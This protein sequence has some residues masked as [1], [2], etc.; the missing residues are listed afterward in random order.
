MEKTRVAIIFGGRSAEHSI[1]LRSAKNVIRSI[2]QSKYDLVF[3]GIDMLGNW[4]HYDTAKKWSEM[5]QTG[6]L[7]LDNPVGKL[8]LQLEAKGSF[9]SSNGNEKVSVDVAFPVLHGPFGEDGSVQGMLKLASIPFVGPSLLGSAVGM[10]KDVMKRLLREAGLPIGKYICLRKGEDIPEFSFFQK[11]LGIPCFVK[12]A[13]LGS[14]VGIS[15]AK[16]EEELKKAIEVAFQYDK[17][18]VIEEFIKGR[19]IECAI[20]GNENPKASVAGE[21]VAHHDFYSFDSKYIDDQGSETVVP[22]D[23]PREDE[24]KIRAFAIKT[25]TTLECEGLS[26]VDIFYKEDGSMFINEINTIP[27]F[28]SI[29]MYPMLWK[30]SGIEYGPLIDKLIQLAFDRF[31][32]EQQYKVEV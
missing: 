30:A 19:E 12:P 2:D 9:V 23:I 18:I 24:E 29:S 27:G 7:T 14:S 5:E 28:T 4:F 11:E 15:K 26:R 22:A 32:V 31:E 16:N 20:L 17:K 21:I 8:S 10:D 13:N 25:F 1:S 3:I 6:K